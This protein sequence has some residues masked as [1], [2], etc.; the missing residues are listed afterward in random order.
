MKSFDDKQILKAIKTGNNEMVLS[1]LY[2]EMLPRIKK[3]IMR[4][5]G[6]EEDVKDVFQDT[7]LIFYNQVKLNK[8]DET[9]DIGGFMF[10]VARN[11]WI[12]KAK[13]DKR[14]IHIEDMEET[15]ESDLSALDDLITVEKAKAIE[16]VLD[17]IGAD[18][19]RLLK[20]SIYD[21]ISLKEIAEKMGFANE[22][23]AKT[24]NYRCKQKLISLVKD[25]PYLISL[26]KE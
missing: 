4:N 18:C 11:L 15:K 20:Y 23:V 25:N 14:Q 24:Y 7:V 8:F 12:N 10:S 5:S 21:K 22:G 16:E 26:F 3:F 9:K 1:N 13:R 19:K 2:K 6:S 17:K